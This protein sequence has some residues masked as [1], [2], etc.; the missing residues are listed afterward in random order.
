MKPRVSRRLGEALSTE[1]HLSP[2]VHHLVHPFIYPT[3]P[4]SLCLPPPP[5]P[6]FHDAP[7]LCICPPSL[8]CQA[9]GKA[10]W[11]A[12]SP[13]LNAHTLQLFPVCTGKILRGRACKAPVTLRPTWALLICVSIL[14]SRKTWPETQGSRVFLLVPASGLIALYHPYGLCLWIRQTASASLLIC[15]LCPSRSSL[16]PTCS[17]YS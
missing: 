4:P 6:P 11:G 1:L 17:S 7:H 12:G 3:T 2:L 15:I 16:D 5:H 8:A 13:A 10:L 9:S 14:T